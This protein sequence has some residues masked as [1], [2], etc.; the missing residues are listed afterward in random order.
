MEII[1][2]LW[3][4]N[5]TLWNSLFLNKNV[6]QLQRVKHHQFLVRNFQNDDAKAIGGAGRI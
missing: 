2:R 3:I 1:R 5:L 4:H 6:G